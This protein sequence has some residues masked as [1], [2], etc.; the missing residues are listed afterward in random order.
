[1]SNKLS[2][3]MIAFQADA[4]HRELTK[5]ISQIRQSRREIFGLGRDWATH[6]LFQEVEKM[7]KERFGI[8]LIISDNEQMGPAITMPYLSRGHVFH[9]KRSRWS[10]GDDDS[11]NFRNKDQLVSIFQKHL[12]GINQRT[13]YGEIDFEKAKLTGVFN[14]IWSILWVQKWFVF[15]PDLTAA[16]ISAIWH[17]EFGH[18]FTGYAMLDRMTTTNM[19]LSL[20]THALNGADQ[21]SKEIC[22]TYASEVLE[23]DDKARDNLMKS[24]TSEEMALILFDADGKKAKSELGVSPYDLNACEWLA[25][26][27]ATRCGCGKDLITGLDKLMKLGSGS[28]MAE[29]VTIFLF[30][31]FITMGI[32]VPLYIFSWVAKILS[33]DKHKEEYDRDKSR[34][35]RVMRDQIELLKNQNLPPEVRKSAL[36]AIGEINKIQQVYTDNVGILESIALFLRKE[37]RT[38]K[39]F[40]VLQKSLHDLA[41]NDLFVSSAKLKSI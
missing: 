21:K 1:M 18:V 31:S 4:F 5:K 29:D 36:L 40:E 38:Q 16:E 8:F 23:L 6:S 25:D 24:K 33:F 9:E 2:L 35:I 7:V 32:A 20:L 11:E 15:H 34:M 26:Q 30:L 27:F 19:N 17:H 41:A 14:D 22:L 28:S 12:A 3:E 10:V 39:D 37:Y 13:A